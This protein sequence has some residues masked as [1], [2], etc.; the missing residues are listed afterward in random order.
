MSMSCCTC[1]PMET[2]QS[3][4]DDTH[5][6]GTRPKWARK[7]GLRIWCGPSCRWV[8]RVAHRQVLGTRT[9]AN[10]NVRPRPLAQRIG[11][12]KEGER[13]KKKKEKKEEGR[14]KKEEGRRKED[15][16]TAELQTKDQREKKKEIK[17]IE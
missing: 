6:V 2:A 11:K 12:E 1:E 5:A 3:L 16:R 4:G 7:H 10:V 17:R 8:A 9:W 15:C 14:R 13:R